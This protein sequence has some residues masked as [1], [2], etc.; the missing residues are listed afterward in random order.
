MAARLCIAGVLGFATLLFATRIASQDAA[1]AAAAAPASAER[2]QLLE[3]MKQ[4]EEHQKALRRTL[5]KM[6]GEGVA[7]ASA[8][9]LDLVVQMQHAALECKGLR[10][11]LAATLPVEQQ[12]AFVAD[13]RKDMAE[14]IKGMLD[15]EIAVLAGDRERS[16]TLYK[17]LEELE[18]GGHEKFMPDE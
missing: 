6:E 8:A 1:P 10:P 11:P 12:A 9:S 18:A 2:D 7:E 17:L 5:R 14:L 4:I 3:W 15:L 13:Y 16:L